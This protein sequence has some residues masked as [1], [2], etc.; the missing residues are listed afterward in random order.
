MLSN[1]GWGESLVLLL[2]TLL[3]VGPERLP[4]LAEQAGQQLRRARNLLLE[5]GGEHEET[6]DDLARLHPRALVAGLLEDSGPATST[7]TGH[8]AAIE[9]PAGDHTGPVAPPEELALAR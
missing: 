4:G 3:V 8:P 5:L 1:L 6:L 7:T 9:V 2:L